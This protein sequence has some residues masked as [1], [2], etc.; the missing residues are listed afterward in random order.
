[1]EQNN[2]RL[3]PEFIDEMIWRV[4]YHVF[5]NTELTVCCIQLKNGFTVTGESACVYP[6]DFDKTKGETISYE[7]AKQK[8][9]SHAGYMVKERMMNDNF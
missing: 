7:K 5:I 6:E 1:M 9:W 4:Q 2:I 8:I 3:T